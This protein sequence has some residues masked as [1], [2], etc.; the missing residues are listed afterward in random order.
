MVQWQPFHLFVSVMYLCIISRC[1]HYLENTQK[2][3]GDKETIEVFGSSCTAGSKPP[4][5]HIYRQVF[6]NWDLL[7]DV[8]YVTLECQI[9]TLGEENHTSWDFGNQKCNR[10]SCCSPCKLVSYKLE[11][12]GKAHDSRILCV[13][14][15]I[16]LLKSLPK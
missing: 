4:K 15:T 7:K 14:S 16:P 8:A 10:K 9:K 12:L 11:I 2:N 13:I 5:H 3:T 1:K 6:P